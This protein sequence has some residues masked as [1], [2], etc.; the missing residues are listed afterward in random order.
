MNFYDYVYFLY[1]QVF[2]H[3]A[4]VY[5][6]RTIINLIIVIFVIKFITNLEV[7]KR[8][9]VFTESITYKYC[10]ETWHQSYLELL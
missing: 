3:V 10:K 2:L 4:W 5:Q 9:E 7:I 1:L 8:K 6:H